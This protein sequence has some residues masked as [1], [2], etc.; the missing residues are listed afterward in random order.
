MEKELLTGNEAMALGAYDAGTLVGTAYPGT[1]STEIMEN[2]A[3]YDGVYAEW[4]VNEKVA[5]ETAAG[6]SIRG[7]RS[8]SAM[9][10]VGLNVAADAFLSF[11]Y[12]EAAGGFVV[13]S[14][15]EPNMYSSQ[16]EQDNRYYALFGKTALI[17][18]SDS[19]E[20]YDFM[21]GAFEISERFKTPVLFRVTTRICHSKSVVAPGE[22][23]LPNLKPYVK[24]IRKN[25]MVPANSRPRHPII[26][27]ERFKNLRE[28]TENCPYNK[29]EIF[30]TKIGIITNGVSYQYAKEVFGE[31][32]SYLKLGLTNP[33]PENMI[34]SFA[35]KVQ[36]LYI[37]EEG[38]P[39]METQIKAMGIK[40]VGKELLPICGEYSVAVL[41]K[42]LLGE[43]KTGTKTEIMAPARPP[44]LCTGCPH[45]GLFYELG[46]YRDKAYLS[47]DIGCYSLGAM[48]PLSAMDSLICMGASVSGGSGFLKATEISGADTYK[49]T[50]SIIGDSTFFHSGITGL[51]NAVYNKSGICLIILD[52]SITGMTG[53][54]EN[55]GS[56]KNIKGEIA[57]VISLE[58]ICLACGIKEKN[59]LVVDPFDLEA[60]ENAL[61]AGFESEE[62]FVIITK[63]L[64]ALLKPAIAERGNKKCVVDADKCRSCKLCLKCGCPALSFKEKAVIDPESCTGCRVCAQ[65]C[66][67]D[68]IERNY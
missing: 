14:A 25:L 67:F 23:I 28:Y 43:E 4:S 38:E 30:D 5:C 60:T 12:H 32:A 20:C 13:I 2:F 59:I 7:V 3:K 61:K 57:P 44:V 39:F 52:N 54:Q 41:R 51:I 37:I 56:G 33:L 11:S 62:T 6:A 45:R 15:D 22:R 31:N 55:P 68:A 58:K 48:Q 34:K 65:I 47:G 42:Y 10:H 49:K 24:D 21:R 63:R 26:E 35:S 46:K 27:N 1:P 29:E 19:Q 53:H 17:E 64:C 36:K 8:F 50:F 18:P 16:N 9:K 40:C 66:P